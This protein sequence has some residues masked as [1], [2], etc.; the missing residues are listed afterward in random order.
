MN[1]AIPP[2]IPAKM[3]ADTAAAA[4]ALATTSATMA[5]L[6]KNSLENADRIRAQIVY[7]DNTVKNDK[8]GGD[9]G[10]GGGILP[11]EEDRAELPTRLSDSDRYEVPDLDPEW[12][13]PATP[14][15]VT[16]QTPATA[17]TTPQMPA[18]TSPAPRV[19]A[20]T[21][22][23]PAP[24]APRPAAPPPAARPAPTPAPLA[25]AGA[26]LGPRATERAPLRKPTQPTRKASTRDAN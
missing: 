11:Q 6:V 25:P 20:G 10:C 7:Y 16:D 1:A 14:Y 24:S 9:T 17:G 15:E 13:P 23:T 12:G 21:A 4:A 5:V 2:L 22:S 3:A 19:P 8:S 26:G 18:P